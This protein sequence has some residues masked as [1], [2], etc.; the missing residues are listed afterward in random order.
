MRQSK[1]SNINLSLPKPDPEA[2]LHSQKL[3][4][5]I[6]KLI[7]E[8]SGSIGFDEYMNLALYQPGL[9]YYSSGNQIFGAKGDFV[10]APQI[11]SLFSKCLASQ[12]RQILE[13]YKEPSI[14]EIGAG[15]GTMARDLLLNL[16]KHNSIPDKYYILEI[17]SDLKL[18]QKQLLKQSIPQYIDNI[19][20]LN[21]L[22]PQSPLCSELN[23]F[24]GLVLVN[25]VLDAL[26][27]R[28]FK[29]ESN[30]FK[31]QKV[32]FYKKNFCWVDTDADCELIDN[33]TRLE[34]KLL[35]PLPENYYSETNIDLKF[36]LMQIKRVMKSGV[37]LLSDY[38]YTMKDYYHNEK[39]DGNLLCHYRHY[40][41]NDPF[42]YPG[43]QDITASVNFTAVAQYAEEIGLNIN[44]YTNQT[45]FL[46]GCG[47][48]NL[49]PD[50]NLL[51]IKSQTKVSQ[52]LRILT[53]PDEMGERFKF[54]ALSTSDFGQKD[55]IG[56]SKMNQGSLL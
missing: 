24:E 44:G 55:L 28:R 14:L 6:K 35:I 11:S 34:K 36:W 25:E 32:T 49:V 9:G 33:L 40:A 15:D 29:K 42:F 22:P 50:M 47:L 21:S 2:K 51:D 13:D 17:S 5:H 7:D 10:T 4:T 38:G 27:V 30:S 19:I 16:E 43:L 18:R 8:K 39:S 26:P 54:M 45:Y 3:S 41:H 20:W 56:F 37:I 48:E 52:E 31:E 23:N 53:M 1:P 46:F 12:C